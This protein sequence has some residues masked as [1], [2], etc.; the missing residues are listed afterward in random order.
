MTWSEP[1]CVDVGVTH[2]GIA[3]KVEAEEAA[4]AGVDIGVGVAVALELVVGIGV[5]VVI[6]VLVVDVLLDVVEVEEGFV[7]FPT[8]TATDVLH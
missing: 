8:Y 4:V 2:C 1:D 7:A 3:D 5:V 6:D